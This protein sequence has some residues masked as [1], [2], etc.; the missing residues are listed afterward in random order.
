MGTR[1]EETLR[2]CI[3]AENA[4]FRFGGE[5]SLPLHYFSRLRKRGLDV[6]LIVHGRTR[7]EL[8]GLFPNDSGRIQFIPDKWFHKLI[9]R[10]NA[11]L[12]RRVAQAT[13]GTLMVLVNQYIQ[14]QMVQALIASHRVNIVHQP[15]PVSPLAPSFICKLGVPVVMGPLNGGMDY[16][17]AFRHVESWITR[18][19]VALG[20]S[21]ANLINRAIPGKKLASFVLVANQRTRLALPSCIEGQVVEIPENGV[22]LELWSVQRHT[23]ID[24]DPPRF[25]FMG[26]L[27]DWK[28]LDWAIQALANVPGASLDVIGDG[29]MRDEWMR[30]AA[31]LNIEDRIRFRGWLPQHEC[32]RL[33]QSATALVLPSIY[34]C[35][36]AV[37]L[38]A[39]AAGVPVI[40]VA[41]GGPEDYIDETCG[42]LVPPLDAATVVDG[43]TAGMK[44][45]I[46]QPQL[47]STLGAAARRRVETTF[48][49]EE[50]VDRVIEIY[51]LAV[52]RAAAKGTSGKIFTLPTETISQPIKTQVTTQKL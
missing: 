20:R 32:A 18:V 34:E 31:K 5:A 51:R 39:M 14:R 4:S 25:L 16:P 41:W 7:E 45:L 35:G 21:C 47:R 22:D 13:L 36:G 9:W 2:I 26:R 29:P 8:E 28:R 46:D 15:I 1:D 44:K 24:D 42:I 3:V 43:F 10:L 19:S 23:T 11:F 50:K 17:K 6:Y 40:A 37:V 38:E 52:D 33:L 12:P 27:V 30:L 48:C 49:W